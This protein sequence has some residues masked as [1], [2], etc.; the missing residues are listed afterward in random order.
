MRKRKIPRDRRADLL[1]HAANV[2]SPLARRLYPGDLAQGLDGVLGGGEVQAG[3]I[4]RW[5]STVQARFGTRIE[6]IIPV[7]V[8]RVSR[9]RVHRGPAVSWR[10]LADGDF[11]LDVHQGAPPSCRSP[12]LRG[13][14]PVSVAPGQ[15]GLPCTHAVP[16]PLSGPSR[17]IVDPPTGAGYDS[18][19]VGH[20]P[21]RPRG[22]PT[23]RLESATSRQE[24]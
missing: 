2:V 10:N 6:M 21:P 14:R 13:D 15:Q 20:G 1:A 7:G 23:P 3:Y 11:G 24:R 16:V 18:R 17:A 9:A 4:F 8:L 5:S 19:P 22:A 12:A